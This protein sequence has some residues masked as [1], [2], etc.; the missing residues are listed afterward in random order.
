[1][2]HGS[3]TASLV[4]AAMHHKLREIRAQRGNEPVQCAQ[5][6]QSPATGHKQ[7]RQP[8]I[9]LRRHGRL[10]GEI[11]DLISFLPVFFSLIGHVDF[12][13]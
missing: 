3:A 4:L 2:L 12:H 13:Q 6:A 5:F 9:M 8:A 10:A 7:L 11:V 1:M